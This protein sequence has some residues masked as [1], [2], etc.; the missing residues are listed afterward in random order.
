MLSSDFKEG[1]KVPYSSLMDLPIEEIST[2]VE[3][4]TEAALAVDS[5]EVAHE[6]VVE[7]DLEDLEDSDDEKE[8][9]PSQQGVTGEIDRSVIRTAKGAVDSYFAVVEALTFF[10]SILIG[11]AQHSS[12]TDKSDLLIH[13]I[14]P[15]FGSFKTYRSI[16]VDLLFPHQLSSSPLKPYI[17]YCT[18]PD[19]SLVKLLTKSSTSNLSSLKSVYRLADLSSNVRV[20]DPGFQTDRISDHFRERRI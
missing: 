17:R 1:V 6:D 2:V 7:A 5:T 8:V 16:F 10:F 13:E 18:N 3:D 12:T 20:V 19:A 4:D 15:R 14:Q 11:S 9:A